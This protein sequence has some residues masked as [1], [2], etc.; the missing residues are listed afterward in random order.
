MRD[1]IDSY[2][3]EAET[4]LSLLQ[5]V[6]R[7]AE[8]KDWTPKI[9]RPIYSATMY[10]MVKRITME[11]SPDLLLF[12]STEIQCEHEKLILKLMDF[13]ETIRKILE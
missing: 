11:V 8:R 6:K 3:T 5:T 2:L 7:W 9:G 10:Q 12:V 13:N 4:K 1:G